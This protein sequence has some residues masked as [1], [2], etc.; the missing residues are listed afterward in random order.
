M[1]L[2]R[3]K[4][5]AQKW[6]FGRKNL[7]K[8]FKQKMYLNESEQKGRFL[9]IMKYRCMLCRVNGYFIWP[10]IFFSTGNPDDYFFSVPLSISCENPKKC[11]CVTSSVEVTSLFFAIINA[12]CFRSFFPQQIRRDMWERKTKIWRHGKAIFG[13]SLFPRMR[14][15]GGVKWSLKMKLFLECNKC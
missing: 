4:N 14:T 10:D 12:F 11:T 7:E 8:Y 3:E 2:I 13:D 15:F 6:T 1:W 9:I 5:A